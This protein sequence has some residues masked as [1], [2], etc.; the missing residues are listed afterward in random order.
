MLGHPAASSATHG[1][2]RLRIKKPTSRPKNGRRKQSKEATRK[3]SGNAATPIESMELTAQNA[4]SM[5]VS[6]RV[7]WPSDSRSRVSATLAML[8]LKGLLIASRHF[9]AV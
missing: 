4:T 3:R 5:V 9:F 1:Y 8:N 2:I 7:P 6:A